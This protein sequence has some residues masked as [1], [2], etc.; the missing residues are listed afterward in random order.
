MKPDLYKNYGN[1][2]YKQGLKLGFAVGGMVV[3]LIFLISQIF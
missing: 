2:R 3:S 1:N